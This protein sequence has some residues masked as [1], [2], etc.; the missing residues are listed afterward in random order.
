MPVSSR[1]LVRLQDPDL[2]RAISEQIDATPDL[3]TIVDDPATP[4]PDLVLVDAGRLTGESDRKYPMLG[5]GKPETGTAERCIETPVRMADLLIRIRA[6]LQ[7]ARD[8]RACFQIGDSVFETETRN[9]RDPEGRVFPLPEKAANALAYLCRARGREIPRAELLDAIWG[10]AEG[11]ES[12]TVETHISRLRSSLRE[13]GAGEPLRTE[14]G[15]YRL[16]CTE[17]LE[18]PDKSGPEDGRKKGTS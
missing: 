18:L 15:C 16:I 17:A 9:L 5:L 7:E 10:Y 12:H 2:T 6:E 3:A 1:I 14:H 13:A 8:D 11:V 4:P